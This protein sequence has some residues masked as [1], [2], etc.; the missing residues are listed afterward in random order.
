M[1]YPMILKTRFIAKAYGATASWHGA[2]K[3][4]I[5]SYKALLVF[6]YYWRT[7][8][9]PK[10]Q[11]AQQQIEHIPIQIIAIIRPLLTDEEE[12]WDVSPADKELIWVEL[13]ITSAKVPICICWLFSTLNDIEFDK[14]SK[15]K[16]K[17]TEISGLCFFIKYL[18]KWF[19]EKTIKSKF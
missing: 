8:R 10:Q 19:L 6:C 2:Q 3:H 1:L 4:G 9:Y 5:F 14:K 16:N 7:L 15:P 12:D 17:I 18:G 11:H 13:F